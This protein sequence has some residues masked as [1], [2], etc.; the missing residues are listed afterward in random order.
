QTAPVLVTLRGSEDWT[1]RSLAYDALIEI[2]PDAVPAIL[3]ELAVEDPERRAEAATMLA[4][5]GPDANAGAPALVPLLESGDWEA[6]YAASGALK[7]LG[8]N[9]E[10]I[11]ALGKVLRESSIEDGV[12]AAAEI[13]GSYGAGAK[14]ALPDLQAAIKRDSWMI[15]SAAEDAIEAIKAAQ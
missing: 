12:V 10:A 11:K 4:R 6:M 3:T 9:P 8:P 15:T 5:I 2:G 7:S 13:L 14:K 1:L